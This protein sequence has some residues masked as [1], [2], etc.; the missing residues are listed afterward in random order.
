MNGYIKN[1]TL[2]N[3]KNKLI[4]LYL[5]NVTD[6]IL[7][8]FLLETGYF[9]ELNIFMIKKLESID[10]S[11]LYKVLLPGILLTVLYLRMKRATKKQ[12][13]RSNFLLNG[14]AMIYGFINISHLIWIFIYYLYLR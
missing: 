13:M 6:L 10:A 7:T 14:I 8:M 1:C 5:L 4:I 11:I 3:L 9:K 12:L 2:G